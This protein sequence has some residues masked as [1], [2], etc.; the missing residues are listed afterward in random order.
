MTSQPET[1]REAFLQWH[2]APE[3]LSRKVRHSFSTSRDSYYILFLRLKK[4]AKMKLTIYCLW[5]A[6]AVADSSSDLL[7]VFMMLCG[8]PSC[9][10]L[11]IL[12][13]I[14]WVC[15][16]IKNT[17]VTKKQ[18]QYLLCEVLAVH[19]NRETSNSE[20]WNMC[21]IIY[22][23]LSFFERQAPYQPSSC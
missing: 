5:S 17:Y 7:L 22:L 16:D 4:K 15:I 10:K 1:Q 11:L 12:E 8:S 2:C 6:A 3:K 18:S 20:E 19:P 14:L 23:S 9:Y 13:V 21:L